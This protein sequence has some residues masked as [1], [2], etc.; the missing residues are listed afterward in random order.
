MKKPSDKPQCRFCG[1][2]KTYIYKNQ[3]KW[4]RD[5][6]D[7]Y[8]CRW[9]YLKIIQNPSRNRRRMQFLNT[10]IIFPFIVRAGFCMMKDCDGI[11]TDRHHFF[12]CRVF[13]IACTIEL[14]D[15]HHKVENELQMKDENYVFD[16]SKTV[17]PIITN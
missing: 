17:I 13:P 3:E 4:Y 6:D 11:M 5:E 14:C 16:W 1:S 9:C 12:Y 15:M 7:Q 10:A 2:H 8:I